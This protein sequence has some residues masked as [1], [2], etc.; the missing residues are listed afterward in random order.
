MSISEPLSAIRH[1]TG[2]PKRLRILEGAYK[3]FL[4]YGFTRTTMDDIAKA[5]DLSR[6]ALYVVFRNKTDIY[7]AIA[8]CVM[9]QCAERA[10]VALNNDGPLLD[11]LD[12]LVEYAL[13]DMMREIEDSPHGLELLDMKN[14][15]AG[16]VIE[17]WRDKIDGALEEAIEAETRTTGVDLASRGFS[18]RTLAQTF[19]DALD[20]MKP[21]L[22][23]PTHHLE[24]AKRAARMLVA[25]IRP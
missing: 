23:D 4:A 5:A 16:D 6:P 2:D 9:A 17:E 15:L 14:S 25:A 18:A 24:A 20:G 10:S 19:F 11:R 3:V 21:R 13:F 12:R 1:D 22:S 7:K 8:R